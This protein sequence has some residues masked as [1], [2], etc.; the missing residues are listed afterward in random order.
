MTAQAPPETAPGGSDGDVLDLVGVGF[1]PSNLALGILLEEE[2][3]TREPASRTT[4][5]FLEKQPHFGWHDGMLLPGTDMQI[6]F[7]KDLVTQGP[8]PRV[9]DTQPPAVSW[10]RKVVFPH[11]KEHLHGAVQA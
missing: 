9:V 6:S 2:N 4:A 7:L 5:R 1:G 10:G 11:A 3:T 8:D